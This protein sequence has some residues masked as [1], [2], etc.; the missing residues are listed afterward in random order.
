M[1]HPLMCWDISEYEEIKQIMKEII[2]LGI[3][4]FRPLRLSNKALALLGEA[5]NKLMKEKKPEEI[6]YTEIALEITK[7]YT[8]DEEKARRMACVLAFW[9]M[10]KMTYDQIMHT[11]EIVREGRLKAETEPQAVGSGAERGD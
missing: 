4:E 2:E 7:A 1:S 8:D 10:L 11:A 5:V 6:K 9:I 3:I